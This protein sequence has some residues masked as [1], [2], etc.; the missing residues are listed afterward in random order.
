MPGKKQKTSNLA[1]DLDCPR[2]QRLQRARAIGAEHERRTVQPQNETV[3][4][5]RWQDLLNL[6]QCPLLAILG[7]RDTAPMD[8]GGGDQIAP[9]MLR[10]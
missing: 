1:M 4:C 10:P 2:H 6:T 8:S 3:M 9:E 7:Y 5:L